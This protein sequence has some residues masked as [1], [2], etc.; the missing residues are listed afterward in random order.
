[1]PGD[2]VA[3]W[4]EVL[5]TDGS[6]FR[7][8][9]LRND[10]AGNVSCDNQVTMADQAGTMP[11]GPHAKGAKDAGKNELFSSGSRITEWGRCMRRDQALF[12]HS[13]ASFAPLA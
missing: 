11:L 3:P 8:G 2:G 6:Q 13:I 9:M 12:A 10:V 1:I 4:M 7:R 5:A